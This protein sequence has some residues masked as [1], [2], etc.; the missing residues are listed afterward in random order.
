MKHKERSLDLLR[1]STWL[2]HGVVVI[3]RFV[4][5]ACSQFKRDGVFSFQPKSYP[6][7]RQSMGQI[8]AEGKLQL[9]QYEDDKI[10]QRYQLHYSSLVLTIQGWPY[11][12]QIKPTVPKRRLCTCSKKPLNLK[13][14]LT[15]SHFIPRKQT[16]L[17]SVFPSTWV[18][19]QKEKLHQ[20]HHTARHIYFLYF[21]RYFLKRGRCF[22]VL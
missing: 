3:Q 7:R 2:S 17:V 8:L 6:I 22:V 14:M 20:T 15:H 11:P 19:K 5:K 4:L 10:G 9:F 21:A 1:V 16:V 13:G 18:E 12:W